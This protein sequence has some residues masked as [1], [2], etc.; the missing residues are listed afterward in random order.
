[1]GA[2]KQE[3]L[4]VQELVREGNPKSIRE[5]KKIITDYFDTIEWS[6]LKDEWRKMR[7]VERNSLCEKLFA[8]ANGDPKKLRKR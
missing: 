4:H 2:G 1:M 6:I 5:V 7:A 3:F 8:Q